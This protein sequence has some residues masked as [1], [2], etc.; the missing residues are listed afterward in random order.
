MHAIVDTTEAHHTAP[1]LRAD[2]P[3]CMLPLVDRPFIQHVVESLV[4]AGIKD[5]HFIVGDRGY[6]LEAFLGDGRRWGAT[7]TWHLATDPEQP[8]ALLPVI[9]AGLDEPSVLLARAHTLPRVT[10]PL[11]PP[12]HTWL[13]AGGA[14]TGWAVLGQQHLFA[15]AFG[16]LEGALLADGMT[17]QS[18]PVL[19]LKDESSYLAATSTALAGERPDLMRAGFELAPGVRVGRQVR[20]HPMA[21]L[22]PPVYIGDLCQIEAQARVGPYSVV[23]AGSIVDVAAEVE[24]AV[25]LPNT[26]LGPKARIEQGL[27]WP[28]RFVGLSDGSGRNLT[29]S[30]AVRISSRLSNVLGALALLILLCPLLVLTALALRLMRKGP[31]VFRRN[32]V[33]GPVAQRGSPWP[34]FPLLSFAADEAGMALPARLILHKLPGLIQVLLGQLDFVGVV[35]RTP[36]ELKALPDAWQELCLSSRPGLFTV[37]PF[38]RQGEQLFAAEALTAARIQSSKRTI[39]Y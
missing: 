12:G 23:G 19:S 38:D 32:V 37:V 24:Q 2:R 26:Y 39:L 25:V 5:I 33:Q 10:V 8:F 35:P 29:W 21:Q 9:G 6:V 34:T 13:D 4:A 14:W 22:R 20:I 27:L 16:E 30:T 28:D 36:E 17:G 31:V 11:P 1:A 18:A 3:A 15:A 7:F